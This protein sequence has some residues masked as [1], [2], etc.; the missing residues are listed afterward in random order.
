MLLPPML[1][2]AAVMMLLVSMRLLSPVLKR[3]SVLLVS[4]VL[5]SMLKCVPV[6]LLPSML[7]RALMMLA[8]VLKLAPGPMVVLATF[9]LFLL[10]VLLNRHAIRI[11]QKNPL[12]PLYHLAYAALNIILGQEPII[13]RI[14][15]WWAMDS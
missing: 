2:L 7:K 14:Q 4:M 11:I 3:A 1:S 15:G 13:P 10:L 12:S 5:P 6:V 8:P 9:L